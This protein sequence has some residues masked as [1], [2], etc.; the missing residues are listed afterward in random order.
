MSFLLHLKSGTVAWQFRYMFVSLT[1]KCRDTFV[2]SSMSSREWFRDNFVS[3]SSQLGE[4]CRDNFVTSSCH[5]LRSVV[6]LSFHLQRLP[7][8]GFV[9]I[10]FPLHLNSGKVS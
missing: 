8:N 2:S 7:G 5:L 1:E 9:T 10:A 3:S 4:R 6:T